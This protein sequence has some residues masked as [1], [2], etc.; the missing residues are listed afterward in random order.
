M[1]ENIFQARLDSFVTEE[2]TS[3]KIII[4]VTKERGWLHIKVKIPEELKEMQSETKELS[5]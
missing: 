3:S 4:G 1:V 2:G 5:I